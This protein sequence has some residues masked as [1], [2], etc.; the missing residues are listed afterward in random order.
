[1]SHYALLGAIVRVLVFWFGG[2][3]VIYLSNSSWSTS[4][5]TRRSR[6]G[7][8]REIK[9]RARQIGLALWLLCI[10]PFGSCLAA[11]LIHQ[12]HLNFAGIKHPRLVSLPFQSNLFHLKLS[13][14]R[15]FIEVHFLV[16]P[17]CS[18]RRTVP[19]TLH[20]SSITVPFR[21]SS[22]WISNNRQQP[23]PPATIARRFAALRRGTLPIHLGVSKISRIQDVR[24]LAR[25]SSMLYLRGAGN[26]NFCI[27]A[28]LIRVRILVSTHQPASK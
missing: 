11:L 25:L 17:T 10:S 26:L 12:F 9:K 22:N 21:C 20:V 4:C 28:P 2:W 6:V 3:V 5:S 27:P 19:L 13:G 14:I 7:L 18:G 16:F 1:M 23:P 15:P 24:M 8:Q